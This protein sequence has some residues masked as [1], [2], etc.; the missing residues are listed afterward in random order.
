MQ[1]LANLLENLLFKL[2]SLINWTCV[3]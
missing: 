2:A 1:K 3:V